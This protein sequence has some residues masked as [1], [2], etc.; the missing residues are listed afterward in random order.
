MTASIK[1]ALQHEIAELNEADCL[2]VMTFVQS[3]RH[4]NSEGLKQLATD[5]I[6]SVPTRSIEFQTVRPIQ[7]SGISASERLSEDRR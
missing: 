6:F 5:P 3:L 1:D 7:A 2:Q 4:K